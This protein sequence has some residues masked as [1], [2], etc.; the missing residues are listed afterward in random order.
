MNRRT[1]EKGNKEWKRERERGGGG[2]KR[3][4]KK[5]EGDPKR[6]EAKWLQLMYKIK[7]S[8]SSASKRGKRESGKESLRC[9]SRGA[10]AALTYRFNSLATEPDTDGFPRFFTRVIF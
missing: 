10:T 6:L 2:E 9:S 8:F 4:R 3:R 1:S 5:R 7:K